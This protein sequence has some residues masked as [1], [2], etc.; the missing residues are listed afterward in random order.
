MT[1]KRLVVV[2]GSVS[3]KIRF[4]L[5]TYVQM[6]IV[7]IHFVNFLSIWLSQPLQHFCCKQRHRIPYYSP[8]SVCG[9]AD[10]TIHRKFWHNSRRLFFC[11]CCYFSHFLLPSLKFVC[12]RLP[13]LHKSLNYDH[14]LLIDCCA[15]I[16]LATCMHLQIFFSSVFVALLCA[17]CI[18][19]LY[20]PHIC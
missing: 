12:F 8:V 16:Y 20:S 6:C 17:L 5:H 19:V 3:V 13:G 7:K 14:K 9:T 2:C 1:K 18:S 15:H 10:Y 4:Q 11:F